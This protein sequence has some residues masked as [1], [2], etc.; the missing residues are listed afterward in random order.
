M[1]ILVYSFTEFSLV[2]DKVRS[3]EHPVKIDN[4]QKDIGIVDKITDIIKMKRLKWFG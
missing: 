1:Q 4:I 2:W 3:I